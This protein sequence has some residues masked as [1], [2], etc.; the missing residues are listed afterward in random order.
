MDKRNGSLG[1]KN[2]TSLNKTLLCTWSWHFANEKKVFWNDVIR[3]MYG[4]EE[5]V[6][7][8]FCKGGVWGGLWKS[9]RK[10]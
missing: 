1:V 2:L 8:L 7:F 9:I 5:G 6:E 3:E 4:E 10:R